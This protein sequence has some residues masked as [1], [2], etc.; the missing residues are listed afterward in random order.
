MSATNLAVLVSNIQKSNSEYN[1]I[2]GIVRQGIQRLR[3]NPRLIQDDDVVKQ[4][5]VLIEGVIKSLDG[6][7]ASIDRIDKQFKG[8]VLK[9]I[10]DLKKIGRNIN[11]QQNKVY[12]NRVIKS[13]F[14]GG[15]KLN[16]K[17]LVLPPLPKMPEVIDRLSRQVVE[18][19]EA[20]KRANDEAA[21][22]KRQN[23]NQAARNKQA[24]QTRI[25]A[26]RNAQARQKA[27][28]DSERRNKEAL[29][30]QERKRRDNAAKA[31]GN[32]LQAQ[33]QQ[34]INKEARQQ[35]LTGLAE[36]AVKKGSVIGKRFN[37]GRNVPSTFGGGMTLA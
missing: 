26:E 29:E 24:M 6:L 25:K 31:A 4:M 14:F 30:A 37:N 34:Q 12:Y 28:A 1:R 27:Q 9:Y 17:D 18:A 11:D 33:R 13:G 32:R 7:N 20:V 21:I 36:E 5:I 3:S 19:K 2:S 8:L 35:R 16:N 22:K 23:A 10:S 15:Y